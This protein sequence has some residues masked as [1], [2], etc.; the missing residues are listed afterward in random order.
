MIVI[1]QKRQKKRK[2]NQ[3]QHATSKNGINNMQRLQMPD[4]CSDGLLRRPHHAKDPPNTQN[5]TSPPLSHS[6]FY[7]KSKSTLHFPFPNIYLH[8]KRP[9][10]NPKF[11]ESRQNEIK[12]YKNNQT[13]T[14]RSKTA[15]TFKEIQAFN[16]NS[17]IHTCNHTNAHTMPKSIDAYQ[18]SIFLQC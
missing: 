12:H 6:D 4:Y 3:S 18:P 2:C 14:L 7:A 10:L 16:M 13:L 15:L 8:N 17:K 11:H 1:R 5:F 9:T